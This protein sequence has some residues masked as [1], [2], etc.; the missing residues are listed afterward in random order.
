M[1][2]ADGKLGKFVEHPN[3]SHPNLGSRTD[4]TP[5]IAVLS[6]QYLSKSVSFHQQKIA[7][8]LGK[9]ATAF[10]VPLSPGGFEVGG[11]DRFGISW[12]SPVTELPLCG[13]GTVAAAAVIFEKFGKRRKVTL[14]TK[15]GVSLMAAPVGDGDR[16]ELRFPTLPPSQGYA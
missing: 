4:E 7:A 16:I 2:E 14:E 15:R 12:H 8:E 11:G 3:P 13:H 5:F 1:T 9:P 6:T 10:V